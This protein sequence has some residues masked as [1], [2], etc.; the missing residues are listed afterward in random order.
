MGISN[1]LVRNCVGEKVF[2]SLAMW[3]KMRLREN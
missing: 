1:V 3:Q 2:W